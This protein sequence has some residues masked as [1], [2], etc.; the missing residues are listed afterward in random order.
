MTASAFSL[1]SL[2]PS[3]ALSI[4]Q[5]KPAIGGLRG[6]S[7]HLFCADCMTWLFTRPE[8]MDDFVNIRSTL[9]DDAA[10]HRPFIETYTQ[11][12]LQWVTTGARHSFATLPEESAFPELLA[13][14]AVERQLSSQ[15]A[16]VTSHL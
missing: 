9:L 2:Y 1:S 6:A 11:E 5:G 15:P 12:K 4:T 7:Q 16:A 8:G 3:G 14:F 13:A 10:S